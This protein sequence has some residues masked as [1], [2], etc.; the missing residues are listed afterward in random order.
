M[1]AKGGVVDE[2][3]LAIIGEQGKEVVMPLENNT[4]WIDLLAQKLSTKTADN[5]ASYNITFNSPNAIDEF[6]AR[7]LMRN[8]IRDIAEGF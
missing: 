6:E 7:R 2:A 1:L 5:N 4:E 3:T 8:T